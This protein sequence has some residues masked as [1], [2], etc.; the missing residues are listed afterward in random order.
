M[1]IVFQDNICTVYIEYNYLLLSCLIGLLQ[2]GACVLWIR[3]RPVSPLTPLSI[4][5]SSST[6][7]VFSQFS[8]GSSFYSLHLSPHVA[9]RLLGLQQCI[10]DSY[11]GP[12]NRINQVGFP[13]I[14]SRNFPDIPPKPL[15]HVITIHH[16]Y[17]F[18]W[19]CL[20]FIRFP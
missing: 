12:R 2:Q 19:A 8:F 17:F 20:V 9:M 4:S 15:C 1:C 10:L 6:H 16:L 3:L 5:L 11:I 18:C 13:D 14:S 7:F